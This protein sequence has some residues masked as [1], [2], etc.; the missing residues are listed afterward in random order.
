MNSSV[1]L[2]IQK[3]SESDFIAD[4]V[5]NVVF[6]GFIEYYGKTKSTGVF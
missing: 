2:N 1:I 4:L 3:M 5:D 6:D